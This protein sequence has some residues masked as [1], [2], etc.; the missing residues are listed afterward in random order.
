MVNGNED[1]MGAPGSYSGGSSGRKSLAPSVRVK[2]SGSHLTCALWLKIHLLIILLAGQTFGQNSTVASN[3][4][5]PTTT[6]TTAAQTAGQAFSSLSSTAA[7]SITTTTLSVASSITTTPS[8]A[9]RITTTTP[10]VASRITT[11][12]PSVASSITTTPSVASRITTTLSVAS[13]ITTT[14]SVASRITTTTPSAASSITTT[15]SV[16]SNSTTSTPT[17]VSIITTTQSV[18]S[19][20]TATP[21]V[22]SNITTT[23]SVASNITPTPS[24]ASNITTTPSVASNITTTQSVASNITATPSV[25]SNSTTPTS[26]AT[27]NITTATSSVTSN[28]TTATPSAASNITTTSNVTSNIT[29]PTTTAAPTSVFYFLDVTVVVSGQRKNESEIIVWLDQVFQSSLEKCLSSST[30]Q[31]T[32]GPT[33]PQTTAPS[34]S[35]VTTTTQKRVNV[36]TTPSL[37]QGMEVSC[38]EKTAI[39]NTKCSV[40][41]RLSQSVPACCILRTLC[42]ASNSSN[43]TVVGN[44]ADQLSS[45]EQCS[46]DPKGGNSCVYSGPP[47]ASCEE[48]YVVPQSNSTNCSADTTSCN[49]SA[50][51][52]RPD[53]YYTF[54]VSVRDAAMNISSFS[55]LM[56]VVKQPACSDN[57]SILCQVTNRESSIIPT[58]YKNASVACEGTT[59]NQT[60]RVV[61]S[62]FHE[63]PICSVEA[64]VKST[65]EAVELISLI[66]R[67]RRAAICGNGDA[68]ENPLDSPL[69]W[70]NSDLEVED[71][72]SEI[73]NPGVLTCQN[74]TNVIQLEGVCVADDGST[75]ASPNV[76][77]AQPSNST[78][79]ANATTSEPSNSTSSANA[80]T[81]QPSNSTSSANATTSQPSNSTSSANGTTSMTNTTTP[82]S[83]SSTTT[84]LNTTGDPENPTTTANSTG[85]GTLSATKTTPNTGN[86][87]GGTTTE[88]AE[89]RANRLLEL[90]RNVSRLTS[91]DIERLVSELEDILSGPTVSLVLGDISVHIV[92]NLLGASPE[93]L[94][95]TS[96]RIIGIVE[97][98]G[99]KLVVGATAETLLSPSLSLAVKPADGTNFQAASFTISD[100]SNVLVRGAPRLTRSVNKESSIPQGS[101]QLPSTLTQNLTP[102]EKLQV[103]RLQFNFFQQS[104]VFQDNS[105]GERKL[106]SGILGASVANLSI[107]GLTDNVVF[108]MRNLEPVPANFVASCVYWDFTLNNDSG[109]WNPDGCF[110]QN[111][112]D[113]ETICACNHLT[114]F[115]ILLALAR[116]PLISRVQ[117]TILTFI[118]YIG[119]GVSAIFLSITLLTYL[120][121]EKLRKDVPSKIL[122]ELCFALLLLNLVFLVDAWLALYPDAVGLCISTAWFLHY[123]LLVSFTWMGLEAVHMYMAI[124]KV[125]NSYTSHYMLRFSVVGWG[126]PMLVVIIVIAIDKNNYGLVSYGRFPDGTT[127]DFCWL[128]N[129]VAFY[130]AVVAYF[131]VIFIFN[132]IMFIV[133]L[134]QLHRV[135]SQNPHNVKH[136]VTVQDVRSV[137]G[138]TL[139]LGLTWGFAFFAWG[140]VNLPFMYLFSIFNSLQGFFIFVFH[141]AVKDNV[142]KQWRTYL[143]CGKMRLAENSEWSRTATQKTVRRS[144]MTSFNSSQNNN[145]PSSSTFLVSNSSDG[146]N[147]IS[148]PFDDRTITADE[149]DVVQNEINRQY[150]NQQAT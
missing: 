20:I 95:S 89:S 61:L 150:R 25:A 18:A 71:F 5:T 2:R 96:N 58:N 48:S 24:V 147:G 72:C 122:I 145:S 140:P 37:F 66:G 90:S 142:R 59:T 77:T 110:L 42:A 118:T 74:G 51:C 88:S 120:A 10:S 6:T 8:V 55:S 87:S 68:S 114:S 146:T 139:L 70:I 125:F 13:S 92:S 134:V 38:L 32:T 33:S 97:T 16:A 123:F 79:S 9:S 101:I 137:V 106:I 64:D 107:R 80:T 21:T 148:S 81:S 112:T 143:C 7:S 36:N 124:V 132:V 104:T 65:F 31:T 11:T 30:G 76:T 54:S 26:S 22:V 67:V 19:N 141:C 100:P 27:A 82:A 105:L 40:M 62:L 86:S 75:T 111:S 144:P 85:T 115:A 34:D 136:R 102:E 133:V 41:L 91:A 121:F 94:S 99:L 128:R 103:S 84:H 127:D 15:P 45:I 83:S 12:T 39:N 63:V 93:K 1:A 29:T 129:D 4:A 73:Q 46:S 117:A 49:C 130:V 28:I 131:C 98:V 53:A 138:I 78:S 56:S 149:V 119:C 43:I 60:C 116:D 52:S 69:T 44:R 35:T 126:V 109:G 14:P 50:Y 108:Q 23:Q 47:G 135:K 57:T 3:V 17:V 113:N